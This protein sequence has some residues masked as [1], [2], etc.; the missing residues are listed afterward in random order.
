MEGSG[1]HRQPSHRP[2]P[3]PAG[4]LLS[5]CEPRRIEAQPAVP[6]DSGEA[7]SQAG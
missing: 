5:H 7:Q 3:V 4:A 2:G 6:W 1:G